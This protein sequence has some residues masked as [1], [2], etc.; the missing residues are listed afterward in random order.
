[1]GNGHHNLSTN[2]KQSPDSGLVY[3]TARAGFPGKSEETIRQKRSFKKSIS[4]FWV[5]NLILGDFLAEYFF[6]K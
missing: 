3:I 2:R 4:P 5:K 1:M 6:M